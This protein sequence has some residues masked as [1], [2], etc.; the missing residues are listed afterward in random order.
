MVICSGNVIFLPETW[1]TGSGLNRL[2]S[3]NSQ[4]QHAVLVCPTLKFMSNCHPSYFWLSISIYFTEEATGGPSSENESRDSEL[5]IYIR[6]SC[7][8]KIEDL[9]R[10]PFI[11]HKSEK[12]L[13][14][15]NLKALH[16]WH[17]RDIAGFAAWLWVK[18]NRPANGNIF[19]RICKLTFLLKLHPSH[20]QRHC[21]DTEFWCTVT[22]K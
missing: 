11:F 22:K 13:V 8:Y 4:S 10:I 16:K 6:F 3:L 20:W 21:L 15:K 9:K 2:T 19:Y 14:H 17:W 5:F 18:N 1:K 7:Y 12:S